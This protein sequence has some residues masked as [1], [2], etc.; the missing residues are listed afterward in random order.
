MSVPNQTPYNIYTA[1]GLT[2][3]FAYEFYLISASDIQV[4]IN[5]NEVTSGYTVSGVGNTGGGE[6]TFLTAPANGAT[7]IFERA[8]P[9]YR[10]TDYQDN[11]D[12]L[13]DTV[14]KDFDRLW[15]AIQRAF[16]YL[17]VALTRPLFGGGP[18]NANGYRIANLADPVSAQDAA[19]KNYV[20]ETGKS[21]LSRTLRVPETSVSPLPSIIGRRKKI[22]A[23]DDIGDPIAVLPESG[24]AADVL[25]E[26]A[27]SDGIKLVG[28]CQ[29]IAILRLI[30]PSADGQWI[31]LE[32]AIP[33][34]QII[35]EILTYD[36]ADTVS[37]D[38]GY[39]VF[40][41]AN[42]RRWK[43]D[44][45]KGYNPLFLLGA[46][47]YESI[48]SCINKIAYDLAVLWG[49]KKGVID[50]CTTIRIPGMP[51][52]ET[53][54]NVTGAIHIPSFVSF[55]LD[56]DTYFDYYGVQNT[57]GI[58][59]DNSYFPMLLD[60]AY[61]TSPTARPR[62]VLLWEAE[63]QTFQGGKLT[64]THPTGAARTSN[65]GITIGNTA[66]GFIDARGCC[67]NNFAS[68]GFYYGIKINPFDNYI[69]SFSNFHL[70]RNHYA[71]AVIGDTKNNAGERFAFINGTL[72]DSD[73]DL[74]YI[75]NNAFEL[76]FTLCSCD[77]STGDLVK[78]T[79][80]GNTYVC[81]DLCHIEGIQGMLVNVVSVNTYPKYGKKIVLKGCIIDVGSGQSGSEEWNK[82]WGFSSVINT[83]LQ[84]DE[85]CRFWSSVSTMSQAKTAYQSLVVSGKPANNAI[86]I[87]FPQSI[88]DL[89]D[90]STVLLGRFVAGGENKRVIS[91]NRYSG[92]A[93][94]AYNA[95][96]SM[97][98]SYGWY[99]VNGA[100]VYEDADV[101]DNDGLQS[102]SVTSDSESNV[103]YIMLS[104]PHE[105]IPQDKFRA[106][107]AIKVAA[108]YSGAVNVACV[109]EVHS[110]FT[111]NS[112]AL[113]DTTLA[114]T[115]SP[116]VDVAALSAANGRIGK[117]Q[118]FCTQAAQVN[119]YSNTLH[120]MHHVRVGLRISGFKGTISL[121]IP[122]VTSHRLLSA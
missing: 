40:V 56:V 12:L 13:A 91:T 52:G 36:A 78:I 83:Y 117:F 30:E 96:V 27:A 55:N 10:L 41:T 122:T 45:S 68:L 44:L 33:G 88:E 77:Y 86:V 112:S 95:S 104:K 51:R 114:T 89:L 115:Y 15:M 49:N 1:N 85:T 75:E 73:S 113:A 19:T 97:A 63:R 18:F 50:Y 57:D 116:A 60:S 100:W 5:G 38:N 109:V 48:S 103:F 26:L 9:T 39:S 43:A 94:S 61:D 3:V 24:S 105:V 4:T 8:T 62:S 42:G 59:I 72:A 23:F 37:P 29:S 87:D 6:V 90:A 53:R 71:V 99:N 92:A 81:F 58:I 82:T 79:K 64:L 21:N 80:N 69:N 11:G 32:K 84:I 74:I 118:G 54:Y 108:G 110:I 102:I 46:V 17:G 16:I 28:R 98:D 14:N 7:V 34:G 120:P 25:I 93:G 65:A 35:N 106:L 76:F 22:L 47:G 107:G 119:S 101:D 66:N 20:D 111:M 121:K 31:V 67:L 2:T 70:G